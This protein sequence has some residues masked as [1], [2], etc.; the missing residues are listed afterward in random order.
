MHHILDRD[1]FNCLN[2]FGT[3]VIPGA[4]R[5]TGTSRIAP[6][7]ARSKPSAQNNAA[8][9]EEIETLNAEVSG[10][11]SVANKVGPLGL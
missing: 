2:H 1:F 10:I 3:L 6:G 4:T 8:K 7:S 11:T 9:D 5:T